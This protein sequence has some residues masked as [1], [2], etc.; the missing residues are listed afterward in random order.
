MSADLNQLREEVAAL[1]R[2]TIP[3]CEGLA[4][5]YS[6]VQQRADSAYRSVG[7]DGA[8]GHLLG[9][10]LTDYRHRLLRGVQSKSATWKNVSLPRAQ[11]ALD[12]IEPQILKDA[13]SSLTDNGNYAKGELKAVVSLDQ[14]GRRITKFYGDN[15]VTW[16]PFQPRQISY[17]T[18][19]SK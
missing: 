19:F 5:E 1:R 9:E 11:D 17:V 3:L 13:V 4:E 7:C 6:N 10:G 16:G 18:G 2:R 12:A 14:T 8:P 15:S